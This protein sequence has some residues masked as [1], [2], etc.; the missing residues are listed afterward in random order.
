MSQFLVLVAVVVLVPAGCFGLLFWLAW[1]EDT[2]PD[3]VRKSQLRR[4]PDP[5]LAIPV[6]AQ[7]QPLRAV[8][9]L[10]PVDS[11]VMP[12]LVTTSP[13]DPDIAPAAAT[14]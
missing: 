11:A 14:A 10:A 2:L 6:P 4:I 7:R 3:D 12:V 9:S 13:A 5:I 1:L 8:P